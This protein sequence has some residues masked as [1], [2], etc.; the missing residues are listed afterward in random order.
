M[1]DLV[2]RHFHQ[3]DQNA[4]RALILA[5]LGEHFAFIDD[6][7][8][9]D[10]DDITSAYREGVFL[11][12]E[13]DGTIAG[14][15]ALMFEGAGVARVSRMFTAADFRRG[16]IATAILSGLIE[17]ARRAA[18]TKVVLST[19]DDWY[20]ALAFYRAF[21]FEETARKKHEFGVDVRLALS[22]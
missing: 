2:V 8:N 6:A 15:G 13:R 21:G 12:A 19:N 1:C 4:A 11:V 3:S 22:L 20:D 18:C 14:T 5:G 16:G 17:E 10:L 9:P 7:L